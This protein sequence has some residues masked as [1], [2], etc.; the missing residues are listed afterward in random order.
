MHGKNI[1][2]KGTFGRFF[3]KCNKCTPNNIMVKADDPLRYYLDFTLSKEFQPRNGTRRD[4]RYFDIYCLGNLVQQKFIAVRLTMPII[5]ILMGRFIRNA[6]ETCR[7][8]FVK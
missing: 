7:M 3:H 5:T 6:M 4:Q 1:A 8:W 2:H